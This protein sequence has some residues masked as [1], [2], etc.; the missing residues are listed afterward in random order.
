MV[1]A[2]PPLTSLITILWVVVVVGFAKY[3]VEE[4]VPSRYIPEA[5]TETTTG[6]LLESVSVVTEPTVATDP[7]GNINPEPGS[8]LIVPVP[9][10]A[11]IWADVV[12][13]WAG[14]LA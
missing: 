14:A 3:T 10:T 6:A 9:I 1:A 12:G 7:S 5:S 11:T 2:G 4:S 8:A 13:V